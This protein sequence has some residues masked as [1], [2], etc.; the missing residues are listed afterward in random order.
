MTT[1]AL[2][3]TTAPAQAATG[4]T[5]IL[6]QDGSH[7]LACKRAV[8]GPFGPLWEI[9]L[10][11]LTA[12]GYGA[13]GSATVLRSGK[14]V[15]K[16][17]VSARDGQWNFTTIHASRLLPDKVDFTGG[18][19]VTSIPGSGGGGSTGPKNPATYLATCA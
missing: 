9:T 3:S 4:W 2:V 11:A 15:A 12:P 6:S 17:S 18:F 1:A 5:T 14:Q 7:V 16:T 19:S 13:S 10:G 8:T